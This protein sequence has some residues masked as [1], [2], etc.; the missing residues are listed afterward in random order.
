[1][2]RV[3]TVQ[4]FVEHEHVGSVTSAAA[5]FV[6]WRIP[7]L[8]PSTRRSATSSR[9][10]VVQRP[11]G[12]VALGHPVQVGHVADELAGGEPAGHRFV[13]GH[14]RHALRAPRGRGADRAR[15]RAPRPG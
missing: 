12:R 7:L 3:G 13:L 15:R 6:R 11:V 8:N 5:I 10:T 2:H 4:R 9:S 14:E 1:M